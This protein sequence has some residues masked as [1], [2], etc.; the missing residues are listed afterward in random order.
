MFL[1]MQCNNHSSNSTKRL[2]I[3]TGKTTSIFYYTDPLLLIVEASN[4]FD[5][6]KEQSST[7]QQQRSFKFHLPFQQVFFFV[8]MNRNEKFLLKKIIAFFYKTSFIFMS[9]DVSEK[10]IKNI[11]DKLNYTKIYEI[12]KIN[13]KL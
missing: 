11:Y 2:S 7:K 9:R 4:Q 13:L 12:V 6:T 10:C 3:L 5:I 8:S 1:M